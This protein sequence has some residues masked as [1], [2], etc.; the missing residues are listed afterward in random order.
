MTLLSLFDAHCLVTRLFALL[1]RVG[2]SWR[3]PRSRRRSV[4][5]P[6][7][8]CS[9]RGRWLL[10]RSEVDETIVLYAFQGFA[11]LSLLGLAF[12]L[13]TASPFRA[14]QRRTT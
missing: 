2:L 9:E 5:L 1:D 11:V 13:R 6:A 12:A 3:T 8:R 14:T 7:I 4:L 10:V